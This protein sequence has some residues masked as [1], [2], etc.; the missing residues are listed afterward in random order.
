MEKEY[1][2]I[3]AALDSFDRSERN[4]ALQT[5]IKNQSSP[6]PSTERVNMHGHTFY[7]YNPYG[8]SPSH[9]AWLASQAGLNVAG[10]V[11]F[12]V[13]DG[14][15]EFYEAGALL[16]L[17]TCC[18]VES[19]VYVPEFADRVINSPGEPG[20]AYHMGTG[21]TALP[22][23]G[24]EADFLAGMK[25]NVSNRNRQLTEAVNAFT[26]PVELDYDQDI[27]SLTPNG[28]ATERHICTAYARKAAAHFTNNGDLGAY[29]AEKLGCDA[30]SLDLPEGPALQGLIRAKTMKQGGVGYVQPSPDSFPLL[31]DMDRFSL[32]CNAIPTLA[33]LDGTT[34]GEQA[35]DELMDVASASGTAA[36]N[37]IPDRNFTIGVKDEKLQNLY[38]VVDKANARDWP[39]IIGTELNS[40][41]NKLV[42]D[43]GSDEL[44]PLV[45][46]FMRGAYILYAHTVLQRQAELGYLS[47][48]AKNNFTTVKEKND[49]YAKLGEEINPGIESGLSNLNKQTTIEQLQA[50]IKGKDNE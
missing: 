32:A 34:A 23:P 15:D 35:M 41:G 24:N 38:D 3:Q 16:G 9:Y 17:K 7:S 2:E 42:D 25:T 36:I 28:N 27:L 21:F 48:W 18:S 4:S 49:F 45:P 11:E 37:I 6:P 31:A 14:M 8:Y 1:S 47:D 33:W 46:T 19:R 43:F 30:S 13:L 40:P 29:W 5:L 22:P 12:D 26:S 10:K 50:A 44:A 39:V 20:I